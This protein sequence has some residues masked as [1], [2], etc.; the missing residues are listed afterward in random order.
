MRFLGCLRLCGSFCLKSER[1]EAVLLAVV[2]CEA[3]RPAGDALCGGAA[4]DPS[5]VRTR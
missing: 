5:M 4:V 1:S 2:L 3:T